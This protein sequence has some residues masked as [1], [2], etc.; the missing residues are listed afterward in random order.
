MNHPESI[1]F[2]THTAV[3]IAS[4]VQQSDYS[5]IALFRETFG[6]I[7]AIPAIASWLL[8]SLLR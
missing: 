6:R 2:T 7:I 3:E 5:A 8:V 4:Q 1:L